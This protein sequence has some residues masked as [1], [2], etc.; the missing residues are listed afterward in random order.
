[1]HSLREVVDNGRRSL[2]EHRLSVVG[3]L[4]LLVPFALA[5]ALV[6]FRG[7]FANAAAALT[8][9]AV[10][11][12]I[13]ILGSRLCGVLAIMSS[14]IWFDYY[15]TRPYDRLTISHRPDL[16]TAICI[17][18]VGLCVNELAA[19]NR[20]W[21]RRASQESDYVRTMHEMAV[22][23]RGDFSVDQVTEFTRHC[24]SQV[25][26]L[27]ECTFE[28]VSSDLPFARI[29]ADGTVV[30]VGLQWPTKELGLP[31]PH[32]EILAQWRGATYGRF[33]LTPTPGQSVSLDRRVVA[34]ALATLAAGAFASERRSVSPSGT[35][36]DT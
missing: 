34:V 25:L 24:L 28:P 14:A 31:G 6:P 15:L 32:A 10:I 8:F 35:S 16:E 29:V 21:F 1:V 36:D 27:R 11:T 23:V 9:L 2:G 12:A 26:M 19:A 20:R 18:V 30:H 3:V 22:I 7:T 13:A 5:L 17:V 33:V 4:A